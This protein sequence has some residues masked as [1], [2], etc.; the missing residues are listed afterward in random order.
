MYDLEAWMEVG[1][2]TGTII[3]LSRVE[4]IRVGFNEVWISNHAGI[5][6]RDISIQLVATREKYVPSN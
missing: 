1:D 3:P 5:Q 4:Y 2:S 6:R